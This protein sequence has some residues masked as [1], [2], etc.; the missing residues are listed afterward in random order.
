MKTIR[1][2][3]PVTAALAA[4]VVVPSVASPAGDEPS[5]VAA[6]TRIAVKDNFFAPRSVNIKSGDIVKWIWR[7]ENA[8]NI[9]FVKVPKGASKRGA[10]SRRLGR[11]RRIFRKPGFYK[12]E[13][14]LHA[15][16]EGTIYVKP[17][18]PIS[19]R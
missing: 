7:G 8:H 11:W 1:L 2:V 18:A 9:T 16:Q 13:C 15:G 5:A 14:T 6:G 4:V 3:L 19:P 17:G 12:F 10:G